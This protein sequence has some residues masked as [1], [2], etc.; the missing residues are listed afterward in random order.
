MSNSRSLRL[1]PTSIAN[2]I[3]L[4]S[5]IKFANT[6]NTLDALPY[7][8]SQAPSSSICASREHRRHTHWTAR[9]AIR[10]CLV[11]QPI[12]I[13]LK[14][15]Y[16]AW[17]T[18]AFFH[19]KVTFIYCRLDYSSLKSV[20]LLNHIHSQRACGLKIQWSDFDEYLYDGSCSLTPQLNQLLLRY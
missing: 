3:M 20:M 8:K 17:F 19:G 6:R 16:F 11:L 10:Q 5:P 18:F 12:V 1:Q 14:N 9:A 7:S 13:V 2:M 4:P 15:W